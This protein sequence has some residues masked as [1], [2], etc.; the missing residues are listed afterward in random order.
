[1]HTAALITIIIA[2]QDMGKGRLGSADGGFAMLDGHGFC[3]FLLSR[4]SR[5]NPQAETTYW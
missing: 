5:Q 4:I 2:P 1:M 3:C